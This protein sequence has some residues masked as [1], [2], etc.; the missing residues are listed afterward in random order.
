MP[1]KTFRDSSHKAYEVCLQQDPMSC[2]IACIAMIENIVKRTRGYNETTL[3]EKS[4][5][6]GVGGGYQELGGTYLGNM[7]LL[8]REEGIP[9][10]GYNFCNPLQM[11]GVLGYYL[12]AGKPVILQ[13]TWE[14][15]ARHYVLAVGLNKNKVVI[16]DPGSGVVETSLAGFPMYKT[17]YRHKPAVG[18]INGWYLPA[19]A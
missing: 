10:P 3:Q 9:S 1:Y 17:K 2:G 18:M 5:E 11:D 15:G 12:R 19:V 13:V 6:L 4:Q 8:L 7:A 14:S 16:C